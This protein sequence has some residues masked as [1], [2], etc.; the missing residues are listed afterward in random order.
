MELEMKQMLGLS[1][2]LL[3][4]GTGIWANVSGSSLSQYKGAWAS[5]AGR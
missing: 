4:L 5:H 1:V 2:A 3:L